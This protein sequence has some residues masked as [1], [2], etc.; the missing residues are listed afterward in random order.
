M[1]GAMQLQLMQMVPLEH[2]LGESKMS[3]TK[4]TIEHGVSSKNGPNI[5][6]VFTSDFFFSVSVA[7]LW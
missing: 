5:I 3:V 6:V 1:A 4:E 2:Y 7:P